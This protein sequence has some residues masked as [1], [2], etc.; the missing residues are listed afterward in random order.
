MTRYSVI[1]LE[2]ID[3]TNSYARNHLRNLVHGDVIQ[4]RTQTAGR[5]RWQRSWIS[6]IP[7]NL[8][9][10]IVLKPAVE[11]ISHAPLSNLSQLLAISLCHVLDSFGIRAELKW[12]NDVLTGGRKIAGILAEAVTEG[13]EFLGLV[14]GIGVNLNLDAATLAG[15]NQPATALSQLLGKPVDVLEFRD[16]LLNEFFGCYDDFLQR[17]FSMIKVDYLARFPFVGRIVEIRSPNEVIRGRVSTVN[18]QGAL[19]I[20]DESGELRAITL[21]EIFA[22]CSSQG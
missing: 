21:G 22:D 8:C 5:G 10:T 19:E 6:H 11:T 2:E 15:I 16:A 13:A 17:G 9:L 3:S 20:V 14:L 4:A 18:D 12:P 1:E 7:G